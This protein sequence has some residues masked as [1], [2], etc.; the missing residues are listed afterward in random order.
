[1]KLLLGF[2]LGILAIVVVVVL[3]AGYFGF[4]PG[5][6]GMFGS[7]K[8]RDL[9]VTYTQTDYQSAR[10]KS[11]I[12]RVDL[13]SNTPPEQSLVFSGQHAANFNLTDNEVTA[14]VNEK[15]WRYFPVH[16]GQVRFNADGTA[17]FSGILE[18]DTLQDYARARGYSEEDFKMVTGWIDKVAIVQS[19]IPFYAKGTASVGSP[20]DFNFQKLELGR[21]SVPVSQMNDNKSKILNWLQEGLSRVNGFSVNKFNISNGQLHFDGTLP[22]TVSRATGNSD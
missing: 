13:P 15:S 19:N 2:F 12:K 17:E 5:V 8:A 4:V 16:D 11:N 10:Q 18:L 9:G 20:M 1:M 14:L 7:N 3:V 6:S 22:D 21:F